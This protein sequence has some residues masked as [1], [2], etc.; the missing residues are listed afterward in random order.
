MALVETVDNKEEQMGNV[1][2]KIEIL[3]KNEKEMLGIKNC[4]R[5]GEQTYGCQGG[6]RREWD[7]RGVWGQ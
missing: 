2:Q 3:R 5:R 4:H 1:S 7:G 6:G